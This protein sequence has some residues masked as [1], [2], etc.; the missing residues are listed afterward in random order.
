M[1]GRGAIR[2]PWIFRQCREIFSG[3]KIS[4]KPSIKDQ[5]EFF[6]RH[7]Q[8]ACDEKGES[9]AMIELRKHF[10]HFLR[11]FVGASQFRDRL[12]RVSTK[13]EMEAIFSEILLGV[14]G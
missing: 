5:L 10:S 11:G 9:H 8:M 6:R 7:A 3:E 1:I 12:I 2:N 13:A 4:A 14:E